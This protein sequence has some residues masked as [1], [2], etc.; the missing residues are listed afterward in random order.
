LEK[1][2]ILSEI[3]KELSFKN[4]SRGLLPSI[5]SL[6][7]LETQF[8]DVPEKKSRFEHFLSDEIPVVPCGFKTARW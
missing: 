6:P 2:E 8:P 5:M 7:I 3:I 4:Y 1:Q